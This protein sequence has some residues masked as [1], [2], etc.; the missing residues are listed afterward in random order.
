MSQFSCFILGE[1]LGCQV[2]VTLCQHKDFASVSVM[3]GQQASQPILF[4]PDPLCMAMHLHL[5][6]SGSLIA[7]N[8]YIQLFQS[9]M[10]KNHK[11]L[12][13]TSLRF[14]YA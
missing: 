14:A 11:I 12:K 7:F 9:H 1:R 10:R 6:E 13:Q 3:D 2:I 8:K 5:M 4:N